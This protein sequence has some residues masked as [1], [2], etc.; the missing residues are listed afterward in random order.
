MRGC[1]GIGCR[2]EYYPEED[3]VKVIL[4]EP[5]INHLLTLLQDAGREGSYYGNR[6]QYWKR[7][8]AITLALYKAIS[9]E[10]PSVMAKYDKEAIK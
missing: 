6:D 9:P 4:T 1:R 5:Q 2:S 10:H 7:H 3:A 8:E